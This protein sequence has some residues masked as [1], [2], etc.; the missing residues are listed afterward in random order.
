M[1]APD[2][3]TPRRPDRY[4]GD[5]TRFRPARRTSKK[6][7][8]LVTTAASLL[9]CVACSGARSRGP[10]GGSAPD[11]TASARAVSSAISAGS[12]L[13]RL[14]LALHRFAQD[15]AGR[16]PITLDELTIERQTDGTTYLK[17]VPLDPW[18][19]PYSY[20]VTDPRFGMYDLR[21]YGPDR[22]PGTDDDVVA[23]SRPVPTH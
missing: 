7:V 4:S 21:S 17:R 18:N 22:Q 12:E 23:S 15:R 3:A 11:E 19:K 6:S 2:A 14:D 8:S 13:K 20:A 1:L 9:L 5:V 10:E 16:L